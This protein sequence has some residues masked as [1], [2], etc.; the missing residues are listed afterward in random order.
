MTPKEIVLKAKTCVAKMA[1]A[2]MVPH[3]FAPPKIVK[4]SEDKAG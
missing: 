4:D 2:N 3:M 1:A